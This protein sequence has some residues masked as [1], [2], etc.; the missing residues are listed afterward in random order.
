MVISVWD[1]RAISV[2]S[3]CSHSGMMNI[4][5]CAEG[6]HGMRVSQ[7]VGGLHFVEGCADVE[8]LPEFAGRLPRRIVTGHC[9][10]NQ[11]KERLRDVLGDRVAFFRTGD[12]IVL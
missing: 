5:E 9:T 1:G 3:P 4:V 12:T 11:A 8:S 7:F 6:R 2:V 10:C